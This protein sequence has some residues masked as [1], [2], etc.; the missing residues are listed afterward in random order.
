VNLKHSSFIALATILAVSGAS[1]AEVVWP[2]KSASDFSVFAALQRFRI[3]ADH[4]SANAP[5]LRPRFDSLMDRLESR[6]Q[7]I[8]KSLLASAVFRGMKGK[9]VPAEI[10]FAFKDSFAD[11]KRNF[12]RL[13]AASICP[14]TL[15]D[16]GETDD[17]SLKSG[18]TEILT[19]VQNMIRNLENEGARQA[20]PDSA[21]QRAGDAYSAR[22]RPASKFG[23]Q[24]ALAHDLKLTRF[25]R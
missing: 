10:V 19:A 3:Y 1:T 8:S 9:P 6:I 22:P 15:Q 25:Q 4:C 24:A 21:L 14:K 13:D 12:E 7:G 17:E 16:L 5:Q 20:S 2:E 11:A 23:S 18:L